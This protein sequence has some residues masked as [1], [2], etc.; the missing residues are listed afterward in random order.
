MVLPRRSTVPSFGCWT[1]T[2]AFGPTP[3]YN[4]LYS[5]GVASSY[6][7][8]LLSRG[9]GA[10]IWLW[11]GPWVVTVEPH[12]AKVSLLG[13]STGTARL[14]IW[15]CAAA[16]MGSNFLPWRS[17]SSSLRSFSGLGV[18][19]LRFAHSS[20]NTWTAWALASGPGSG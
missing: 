9:P 13:N 15:G 5:V 11:S 14:M 2:P 3:K 4:S 20:R 10:G 17:F 12:Q 1:I 18:V 16:A 19:G 8:V 6:Q 7:M